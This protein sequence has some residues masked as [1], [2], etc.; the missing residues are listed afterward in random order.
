MGYIITKSVTNLR[1]S[2]EIA[3][4]HIILKFYDVPKVF[5]G[6]IFNKE[7]KVRSK[8]TFCHPKYFF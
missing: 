4:K 1:N 5:L 2:T 6:D 3:C 7:D 8:E